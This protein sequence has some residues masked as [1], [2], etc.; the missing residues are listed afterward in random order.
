MPAPDSG[1]GFIYYNMAT[2]S[3]KE[4]IILIPDFS[5][6]TQ[7]VFNTSLDTGEFI[8]KELL[9]ALIQVNN[10]SFSISEIE[11]DAI[12][13]YQY[14]RHPSYK[15]IVDILLRMSEAFHRKIT[16]LKRELRMNIGLS[17][18]FIVHHGT[19]TLYHIR[20][21]KKLYGKTV[22]EAHQLLKNQYALHPSYMLLTNSFLRAV[23]DIN[24]QA[25][26][27]ECLIPEIGMI[28]YLHVPV[29]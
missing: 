29:R 11:G 8:V 9:S 23:K 13:F 19:F 7:F 26:E 17:I 28:Q 4:G 2:S 20:H 25:L 12:L 18:K 22:V 10:G 15:S 27:C 21:F 16:Q 6:F 24:L 1:A 5:G 14:N 3:V